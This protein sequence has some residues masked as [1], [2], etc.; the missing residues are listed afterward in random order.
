MAGRRASIGSAMSESVG[1]ILIVAIFV[2]AIVIEALLREHAARKAAQPHPSPALQATDPAGGAPAIIV[3]GHS[4]GILVQLED[5][6]VS[7]LKS[8]GKEFVSFF[9]SEGQKLVAAAKQTYLGTLALNLVQT[10]ESQALTGEQKMETVIA[11]ITPAI[12][13][14]VASGG[15]PGLVT[16]VEDFAIEFAQS[17]YNDFRADIA[18]ITAPQAEAA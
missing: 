5:D 16:S 2:A 1:A 12:Q 13:K 11:M 9:L 6:V 3:E 18:K 7:F 15:L 14:F 17:V 4:M 10:L 8:A